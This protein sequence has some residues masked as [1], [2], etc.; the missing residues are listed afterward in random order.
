MNDM[1]FQTGGPVRADSP[2]YIPREADTRA[3]MYLQRMD[4]ITLVEPREQGKTGLINRLKEQFSPQGYA[5]AIRDLMPDQVHAAAEQD[6]YR[7]LGNRLLH[8]LQFIPNEQR[9]DPPI[10]SAV[11][12]QF[13][14]DIAT[15]A[16]QCGQRV[17]IVLDE[18]GAMPPA[19]ATPFFSVIRSIYTSR[20]SFSFWQHLTFI[21]AGAFNPK[22]LIRDKTVSNFNIDQRIPLHDFDPG[23]VRQLTVHLQLPKA[24]TEALAERIHYWTDGQPYLCQRLCSYLVAQTA[25]INQENAAA[26]VDTAVEQFFC[27]DTHHLSRISDLS[28]TPDL[29]D[30]VRRITG[31]KPARFSPGVNPRQFRLAHISGVIKAGPGRYCQIRNRIYAH[32]LADIDSLVLPT[33]TSQPEDTSFDAVVNDSSSSEGATDVTINY[34]HGLQTLESFIKPDEK[35]DDWRNFDVNKQRLMNNL[36]RER[37]FGSTEM[38]RNERSEI[39]DALN[40]L[41]LRLTGVSFT[42]LALGKTPR[43]A[44]LVPEKP[45]RAEQSPPVIEQFTPPQDDFTY[46][47]F[48]S[49]S[50][51]DGEWVEKVLLDYLEKKQGLRACIDYRDF[52]IGLTSLENIINATKRSRTTLLVMTPNWL[53]S[54]W[55][56]FERFLLQTRSPANRDRRFLLLLWQQTEIPE[57]LQIFT[58]LDLTDKRLDFDTQMKRLLKAIRPATK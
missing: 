58:Y 43:Y 25:Q 9:P 12:E 23:Q 7:S 36:G 33:E 20:Q 45:P 22:D 34:E 26:V 56:T 44:P 16:E 28:A 57:H 1:P 54:E 40:P 21:I 39:V 41:A 24:I 27:D 47:V 19:W 15:L 49:Y 18:I 11:W 48:I 52:E 4:Y 31:K 50:S 35:S 37:R 55:T 2:V 10:N 5:F 51:K 6:W 38:L 30:Y 3:A 8:Q 42:D 46:D 29:L 17:V 14:A 13:L 32:A 53:A